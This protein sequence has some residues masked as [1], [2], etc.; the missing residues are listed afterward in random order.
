MRGTLLGDHG[1]SH[2][3]PIGERAND[4]M[5]AFF[6]TPIAPLLLRRKPP[7]PYIGVTI[8]TPVADIENS[9]TQRK[10]GRTVIPR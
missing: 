7:F 2:K 6:G 1:E 8:I 4:A 10:I 9:L 5:P 3:P